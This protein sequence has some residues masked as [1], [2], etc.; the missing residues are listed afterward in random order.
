[1]ELDGGGALMCQ[2]H[3]RNRFFAMARRHAVRGVLSNGA[4]RSHRDRVGRHRV[5]RA[6]I[7][8]GA[9]GT[10]EAS[11]ALWPGW[12]RRIEICGERGSVI[13]ETITS[14]NGSFATRN[15]ATTPFARRKSTPRCA[16]A[17]APE[18]D[19]APRTSPANPDLIDALRE[20]RRWR[21]MAA[22]RARP[23]R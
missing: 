15:R 3:S 16:P 23:S 2:G 8:D 20:N 1:L 9:L 18:R 11:T 10:I 17:P 4:A 6:Q 7:S 21:S 12:Q 5:G 22:K 13:L 14:P 19:D